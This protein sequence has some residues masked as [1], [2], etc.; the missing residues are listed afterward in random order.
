MPMPIP[1]SHPHPG[2]KF[3]KSLPTAAHTLLATL[4]NFPSRP[5]L[6]HHDT[7]DIRT[8]LALLYS[9]GPMVREL[10]FPLAA[11]GSCWHR[12][13]SSPHA[14]LLPLSILKHAAAAQ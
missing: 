1:V 2:A 12:S 6:S 7:P 5:Y 11:C 8:L 10:V 9:D 14:Y 13:S 4:V 3:V